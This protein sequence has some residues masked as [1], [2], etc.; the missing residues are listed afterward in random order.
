MVGEK[1]RGK[2]KGKKIGLKIFLGV[3]LLFVAVVGS[4][5]YSLYRNLNYTN[6]AIYAPVETKTCAMVPLRWTNKIQSLCYY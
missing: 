1:R 3:V 2:Q 4:Y 5:A 6:D